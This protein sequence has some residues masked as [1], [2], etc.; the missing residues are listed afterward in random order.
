ME[1]KAHK[2]ALYTTILIIMGILWFIL[3]GCSKSIPELKPDPPQLLKS[4]TCEIEFSMEGLEGAA[5]L[6]RPGRSGELQSVSEAAMDI[7]NGLELCFSAPDTLSGVSILFLDGKARIQIGEV[8]SD[9][10]TVPNG[11]EAVLPEGA[12]ISVLGK[13]ME[14]ASLPTQPKENWSQDKDNS[15][16]IFTGSLAGSM[17]EPASYLGKF[18]LTVS[19][20][21]LPVALA[22]DDAGISVQFSQVCPVI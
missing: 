9:F 21:G 17:D 13:A 22:V 3:S 20:D 11:Q 7:E 18:R 4:F 5:H 6:E 10:L 1:G 16:W 8:M 2:A 15:E 12:F 14:Q 19:N